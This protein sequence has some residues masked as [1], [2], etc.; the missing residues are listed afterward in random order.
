MSQQK[1]KS[2]F[3][4]EFL[5]QFKNLEEVEG[6]V[7]SLKQAAIESMLEGELDAHLGYDYYQRPEE[8]EEANYRNGKRKKTVKTT[9]GTLDIAVPLDRNSSFEPQVIKKR[10]RIIEELEER[11]L[12]LYA[13]GMSVRDIEEQMLEIYGVSVSTAVISRVT[14]KVLETVR[15]WQQRPL[16]DTFPVIWMDGIRF[17]VK[18]ER[19]YKAKVVYLVIG[20][21][22]QGHKEVL[23]IWLD[24]TESAAFWMKVLDDMKHRGVR[25]VF[26]AAT[27]NL[28][29]FGEAIRAV[30]PECL[31]QICIVHQIRNSLKHVTWADRKELAADLKTIYTATDRK[32][33]EE[34]LLKV[35]EKWGEKYPHIFR[36]W[37]ENWEK[38]TV[39]FSYPAEI[40]RLIYTTNVIENLNRVLRKYT[41]GKTIFPSD[42]AVQKSIYLAVEHIS[43]K[44][45]MPVANWPLILAQFTILYPDKIKLQL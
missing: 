21:N 34:S 29:G 44:W 18:G 39:F 45:S 5:S 12:S 8:K 10:Q 7:A 14:D 13:K 31:Q 11:I 32:E 25:Q 4:K 35:E 20:L 23:G 26:I 16:E 24:E 28:A 40:R 9:S 19:G 3:S 1:A 2:N 41:K 33:A 27:D 38:L 22:L 6:Y 43:K 37:T 15:Q 36:S 42:E 30:Y 17:K